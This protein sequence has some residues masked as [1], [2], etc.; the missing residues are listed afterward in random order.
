MCSEQKP[1]LSI[2]LIPKTCHY[3]NVRTTIKLSEWDKIRRHIYNLAGYKCQICKNI[4][5]LQGYKHNLECHEVWEYNDESQTQTLINLE[6]LCPICHLT[7][8]I[9]RAIAMKKSE[10]CIRHLTKI[11]KW[12]LA[13]T[14]EYIK[15]SFDKHK[16]R[17]KHK[18]TLDLSILNDEPYNLNIDNKKPRIFKIKKYK[19]KRKKRVTKVSNKRPPKK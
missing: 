4:G 6:A 9:G 12:T 1:K 10:I 2:E 8:H 19:K 18:W 14:D 3:S 11:N 17:S 15:C 5:T 16:E 7:K 13:A